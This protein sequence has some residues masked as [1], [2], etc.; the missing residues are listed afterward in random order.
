MFHAIIDSAAQPEGFTYYDSH[1]IIPIRE[2]LGNGTSV[3]SFASVSAVPDMTL[4]DILETLIDLAPA[5][6][7]SVLICSHGTEDSLYLPIIPGN[8]RALDISAIQ[9]FNG[10]G[11]LVFLGDKKPFAGELQISVDELNYLQ[12]LIGQVQT[13]RLDHVAIR[14]C[15]VGRDKQLMFELAKL[16]HCQSLSAPRMLDTYSGYIIPNIVDASEIQR[17]VDL[18]NKGG[19]T[20]TN[21]FIYGDAPNRLVVQMRPKPHHRFGISS[22]A[23]SRTA[24]DNFVKTILPEVKSPG[25]FAAKQTIN[26][27]ALSPLTRNNFIYQSEPEYKSQIA[28][29]AYFDNH[30][31]PPTPPATPEDK[32]RL[33]RIRA[34]LRAVV[35]RF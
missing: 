23:E 35:K 30:L 24:I 29:G 14:A 18:I 15:Q 16:F 2:E 28:F 5:P 8:K 12:L 34:R 20:T 32:H 26:F 9:F 1:K 7:S 4:L 3:R 19:A 11:D 17:T 27:H 21:Y 25:Q 13:L 33:G 31:K 22:V 6:G 10:W